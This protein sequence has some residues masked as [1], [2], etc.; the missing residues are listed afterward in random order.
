[1][2]CTKCGNEFEGNFCPKCGQPATLN[3]KNAN[4]SHIFY[5][6]DGDQIDLSVIYGAYKDRKGITAFF[7]KCTAYR[8]DEIAD[9]VNY[10]FD[11][12]TPTD[13]SRLEAAHKRISIES[14]IK[15]KKSTPASPEKA[16]T[17]IVKV[18]NNGCLTGCLTV[19]LIFF[20][21]SI[22]GSLF[23]PPSKPN[24]KPNSN[25]VSNPSTL[26]D[27]SSSPVPTIAVDM[28]LSSGHYTAGIDFPAGT[29]DL[30]AV[31]GGGNV[32]SSNMYNGGLNAVMGVSS[33][34][35]SGLDVYEQQYS[36]IELP[37]GTVLSISG[38]TIKIT[39]DGASGAPLQKRDQP[40]DAT[41]SLG[42]GNF[43]AGEDFPSGTY[44]I[45]AIS[46]GGNV[47]SDNMYSGGLN[48][49][50]GTADKNAN[51]LD[52]YIQNFKNADFPDGTTLTIS[53]VDIQLVPSK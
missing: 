30:E 45:T 22:I 41:I 43:V 51:M 32:S 40:I 37:E 26:S 47:S 15:N 8:P 29:Y 50:M 18:Q 27:D 10:I 49:V 42:N 25:N 31:S 35:I 2:Y 44:D 1:M 17:T 38:P 16:P 19:V 34:N 12:V 11:Y 4:T 14:A 5:D 52:I 33:K 7:N 13:Y 46:G 53:G 6:L 48:V 21:L 9:A 20:V 28:Q 3:T 36:N 39:S 23:S 24:K